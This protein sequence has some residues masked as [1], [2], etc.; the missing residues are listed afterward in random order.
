VW[1]AVDG[2]LPRHSLA[3][4]ARKLC[5]LPRHSLAFGARK[6]CTLARHSLAFGARKLSTLPRHS[7][8]FG[9]R[10][11]TAFRPVAPPARRA[12]GLALLLL[13]GCLDA[14]VTVERE[15]PARRS[16]QLDVLFVVADAGEGGRAAQEYLRNGFGYFLYGL[17]SARGKLPDLHV[18]LT[19]TSMGAGAHT[20]ELADCQDQSGG[21]LV[22]HQSC[23]PGPL[24]APF[25]DITADG[26]RGNAGTDPASVF[27]CMTALGSQG[28]RFK[29][30]LR[31]AIAVLGQELEVP[32][33]PFLRPGSYR[34][35]VFVVD[36]DD[37]SAPP[38][39]ELFDPADIALGAPT[40]FRCAEASL[41]CG[42]RRL[43]QQPSGPLGSCQPTAIASTVDPRHALDPLDRLR[44]ELLARTFPEPFLGISLVGHIATDHTLQID[45]GPTGPVL[46]PTCRLPDGIPW[47]PQLRLEAVS[48]VGV[49]I[50]EGYGSQML[51]GVGY[52]LGTWMYRPLEVPAPPRPDR[53]ASEG[54]RLLPIQ[55]DR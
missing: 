23:A 30:P 42:G 43:P 33:V 26:T 2:T 9:A 32:E 29:Q 6:L 36:E 54:T 13:S 22:A 51:G 47:K 16:A 40:S 5:T 15:P 24:G 53:G 27:E 21:R 17:R 4:G 31:A 19:T 18:G 28:C 46:A 38:D 8:A 7:L 37:C 3:F 45:P 39:T 1:L 12:L 41:L 52:M 48:D 25:L 34:A 50:C 35:V 49:P 10:K 11:L 44:D 55:P 20:A 14:E